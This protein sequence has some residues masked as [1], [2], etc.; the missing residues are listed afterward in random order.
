M[1][2]RIDVQN[3]HFAVVHQPPEVPMDEQALA[4]ILVQEHG[5]GG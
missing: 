3:M 2:E 5:A 1:E 4:E